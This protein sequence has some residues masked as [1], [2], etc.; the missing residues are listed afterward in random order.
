MQNLN[1][2]P[3]AGTFLDVANRANNNFLAIKTAIETLEL[4]T[5]RSKGFF[6]S[7]SALSTKYP[8]PVVGDWAVVQDTSVSPPASYIWKCTT[9]GTWSSTNTVWPGGSVDLSEYVEIASIEDAPA[10]DSENPISSGG[11]WNLRQD[12][13]GEVGKALGYAELVSDSVVTQRYEMP[14]DAATHTCTVSSQKSD[15]TA[16]KKH[17]VVYYTQTFSKGDVL[18]FHGEATANKGCNFGFTTEDPSQRTSIAGLVVDNAFHYTG[19]LHDYDF[20]V[21]YDGAYFVRYFHSDNWVSGSVS[22]TL[23]RKSGLRDKVTALETEAEELDNRTTDKEWSNGVSPSILSTGT[24]ISGGVIVSGLSTG[25]RLRYIAIEKGCKVKLVVTASASKTVTYGFCSDTPAIGAAVSSVGSESGTSI[26]IT[27]EAASSGYFVWQMYSTDASPASYTLDIEQRV[28]VTTGENKRSINKLDYSSNALTAFTEGMK[29]SVMGNSICTFS[30]YVPS[31]Y[32]VKYPSSDAGNDVTSVD[33]TWWWQVIASLKGV[34]EVDNSYSAGRVTNTH[35]SYPSYIDRYEDAGIG[36]PD[37]FLLWG[38]INDLRN[39]S[40]V[41][42]LDFTTPTADLDES[43]F[44]GAYDKLIRLVMADHPNCKIVAIIEP[45]LDEDYKNIIRTVAEHY[46]L[47][48]CIDL[49]VYGDKIGRFDSLHPNAEGMRF[50]AKKIVAGITDSLISAKDVNALQG[51]TDLL[52]PWGGLSRD[53]TIYLTRRSDGS[54]SYSKKGDV[55]HKKGRPLII[56]LNGYISSDRSEGQSYFYLRLVDKN[57]NVIEEILSYQIPYVFVPKRFVYTPQNDGYIYAWAHITGERQCRV[58]VI[59]PFFT[60][61]EL[62]GLVELTGLPTTAGYGQSGNHNYAGQRVSFKK[63]EKRTFTYD[64]KTISCSGVGGYD[65][66]A[67]QGFTYWDGVG[68]AFYDAGY[69]Q[70]INLSDEDNASVIASFALPSG[71]QNPDNH[72]GQAN[73]GEFYDPSDRFPL[74][75]LSSYLEKCCYVLRMTTTGA[76]LVQTLYLIDAESNLLDAQ[77]FFVDGERLVIKMGGQDITGYAYKYWKV[78]NMPSHTWGV[79]GV[80]YI[81]DAQ[82][83][84]EFYMRTVPGELRGNKNYYNAGFAQDG[85]IY[86]LAGFSGNR[87]RMLVIDYEK[88]AVISDVKWDAS[89]MTGNEQEQCCRIDDKTMLINYNGVDKFMKV[90]FL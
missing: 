52:M 83:I 58:R 34:L 57:E 39:G 61:E 55:L 30:G 70:T 75:Y 84:D 16:N 22:L 88:H 36:N 48:A 14:Y 46:D 49:S 2:I 31:G 1:T 45:F 85:R 25:N 68:F 23:Y 65:G 7:A 27:V 76:T 20:V 62:K 15:T 78:F 71:V 82:K 47:F 24:G 80:F 13:L 37:V 51:N 54:G 73:W 63:A 87:Q 3:I 77:A 11:A 79:N 72:C 9:N 28:V 60:A 59:E 67:A 86:V 19:T 38:G 66:H 6:S 29:I 5:T 35:P 56:E 41:G 89:S 12:M 33:Q 74:L 4:S 26:S 90:T 69:C 32:R 8:S 50:I 64:I 21:P 10:P 40:I 17:R 42:T 44:A 43:A 81:E 53:Y 18:H